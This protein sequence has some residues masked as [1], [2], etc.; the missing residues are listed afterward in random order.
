MAS[1]SDDTYTALGALGYTGSMNDRLRSYMLERS[2]L[3]DTSS[4][5]DLQLDVFGNVR[6][7]RDPSEIEEPV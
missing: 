7:V 1:K 4:N 6:D 2:E 3:L 5:S